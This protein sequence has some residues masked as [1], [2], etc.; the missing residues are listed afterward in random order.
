MRTLKPRRAENRQG[1]ATANSSAWTS[2]GFH[3]LR[4]QPFPLRQAHDFLMHVSPH[5][6]RRFTLGYHA[7]V[8]SLAVEGGSTLKN[9]LAVERQIG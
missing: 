2:I 1:I 7:G 4:A 6:F 5:A 9:E 3:P 8:K